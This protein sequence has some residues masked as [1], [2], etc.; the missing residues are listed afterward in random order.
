MTLKKERRSNCYI[1]IED[2]VTFPQVCN[3]EG[4]IPSFVTFSENGWIN[5]NI[6][7]D[8][9]KHLDAS[10]VYDE[11]VKRDLWNCCIGV[12]HGTA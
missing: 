11:D 3:F 6:L 12:P 4:K 7:T 1:L 2:L 8:I 5:G 9:L 10:G